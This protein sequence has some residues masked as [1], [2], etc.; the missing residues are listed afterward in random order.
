MFFKCTMRAESCMKFEIT[1]LRKN[2][3]NFFYTHLSIKY[4]YN[5]YSLVISLPKKH[6]KKMKLTKKS[7]EI[8]PN[9]R[10]IYSLHLQVTRS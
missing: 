8:Y 1:Q 7:Y 10:F 6:F 3:F 9:F 2:Q 4:L 5:K